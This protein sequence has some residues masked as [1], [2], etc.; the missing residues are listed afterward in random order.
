MLRGAKSS[1]V[2]ANARYILTL[3]LVHAREANFVAKS[4]PSSQWR[5]KPLL[6]WANFFLLLFLRLLLHALTQ[7]HI[8]LF[9]CEFA[10]VCECQVTIKYWNLFKW[11]SNSLSLAIK[12][13]VDSFPSFHFLYLCSSH[14]LVFRYSNKSHYVEQAIRVSEMSRFVCSAH[15]IY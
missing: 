13:R 14:Q 5:D 7:T 9:I 6:N 1:H 11:K 4:S 3:C 15:L 10:C 2:P 8:F 12:Y